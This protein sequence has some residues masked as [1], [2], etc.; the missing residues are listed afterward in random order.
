MLIAAGVEG[1]L[2]RPRQADSN[3]P[4]FPAG[5]PQYPAGFPQPPPFPG[6]NQI[7]YYPQTQQPEQG[8]SNNYKPPLQAPLRDTPI[9]Q[10]NT[11]IPIIKLD[12]Q[13]NL[14]DGKYQY[15]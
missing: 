14:G 6:S 12:I 9:E 11:P 1:G 15:M 2:F 13:P 4:Q 5:F 7:P 3:S 8:T 10:A